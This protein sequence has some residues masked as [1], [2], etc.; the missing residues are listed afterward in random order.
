M[1][2]LHCDF[3]ITYNYLT[4]LRKEKKNSSFKQVEVNDMEHDISFKIAVLI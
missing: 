4:Q 2:K 1:T 3:D